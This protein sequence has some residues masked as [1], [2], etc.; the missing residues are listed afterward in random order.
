LERK[1]GAA[2]AA[3]WAKTKNGLLYYEMRKKIAAEERLSARSARMH[4][5]A[6]LQRENA[7]KERRRI[8]AAMWRLFNRQ[9][10]LEK[11][12]RWR[13]K[14]PDRCSNYYQ[15]RRAAIQGRTR[16]DQKI[17][18]FYRIAKSQARIPCYLCGKTTGRKNRHVDHVVPIARGGTHSIENLAMMCSDC[19]T[20]KGAKMPQEVG[21]LF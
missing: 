12:K 20:K 9:E 4:P 1:K 5:D 18:G 7:R 3:V 14:N 19:N 21:L 17:N 15:R 13:S 10:H 2:R 16:V 11:L 8:R 6:V